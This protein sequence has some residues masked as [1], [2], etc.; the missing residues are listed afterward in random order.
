MLQ[1]GTN[2]VNEVA[3]KRRQGDLNVGIYWIAIVNQLAGRIGSR[4]GPRSA[5][6]RL[7]RSCLQVAVRCQNGRGSKIRYLWAAQVERKLAGRRR[8]QV[9]A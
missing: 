6:W 4:Q 2:V 1:D 8:A 3:M 7:P 9:G 5:A